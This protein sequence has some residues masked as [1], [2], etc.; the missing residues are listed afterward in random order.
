MVEKI[1]NYDL[2][3]NFQNNVDENV[4]NKFYSLKKEV[5]LSVVNTLSK[6]ENDILGRINLFSKNKDTRQVGGKYSLQN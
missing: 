1:L 5:L 6:C 2:N 3:I 4:K